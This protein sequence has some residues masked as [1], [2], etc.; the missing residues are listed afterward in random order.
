MNLEIPRSS[1]SSHE[2]HE[3]RVLQLH[4]ARN[5]MLMTTQHMFIYLARLAP[6]SFLFFMFSLPGTT[7]TTLPRNLN[8]DPAFAI[9]CHDAFEAC[10]STI[11]A[12]RS[13]RKR[14]SNPKYH[15][16]SRRPCSEAARPSAAPG[17]SSP[18]SARGE[19]E[20]GG[21]C[22]FLKPLIW[23]RP[24]QVGWRPS[25]LLV[26]KSYIILVCDEFWRNQKT[27]YNDQ[28][29]SKATLQF[30]RSIVLRVFYIWFLCLTWPEHAL[31]LQWFNTPTRRSEAVVAVH[32]LTK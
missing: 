13:M 22:I 25:L 11:Y 17:G 5:S 19:G 10:S 14:T 26:A 27:F 20:V 24:S 23:W 6:V 18:A 32:L 2:S 15:R 16:V 9:I 21:T 30:K 29:T 12:S 3:S 4:V 1:H 7:V 31:P 28:V 8:L